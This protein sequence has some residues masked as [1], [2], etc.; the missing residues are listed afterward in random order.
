MYNLNARKFIYWKIKMKFESDARIT[1]LY[2]TENV[3]TNLDLPA[4]LRLKIFLI[5]KKMEWAFDQFWDLI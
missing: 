5:Q 1:D 4:S 2:E 3:S